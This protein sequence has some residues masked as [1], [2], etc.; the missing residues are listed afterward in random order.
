[1]SI[2]EMKDKEPEM[3]KVLSPLEWNPNSR[4]RGESEKSC[5]IC[6]EEET[7]LLTKHHYTRSEKSYRRRKGLS[8][9]NGR[10]WDWRCAN[11]HLAFNRLGADQFYR[12]EG[13]QERHCVEFMP[14]P[15][16]SPR[17]I[18]RYT[19]S[20]GILERFMWDFDSQLEVEE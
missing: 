3:W 5:D 15:S 17:L 7:V 8:F 11:C 6:G 18:A 16:Q 9:P 10:P 4:S 12:E 1:M 14:C 19:L 2:E 20:A 13:Y